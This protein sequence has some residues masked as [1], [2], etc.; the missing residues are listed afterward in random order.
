MDAYVYRVE[1]VRVQYVSVSISTMLHKRLFKS[2]Q[3]INITLRNLRA[4]LYLKGSLKWE[5]YF[6]DG[7]TNINNPTILSIPIS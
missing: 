3:K 2:K 6:D 1:Y 7:E 5:Y 4:T